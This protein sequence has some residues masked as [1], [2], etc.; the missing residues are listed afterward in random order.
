MQESPVRIPSGLVRTL[1]ERLADASE[2]QT[3]KEILNMAGKDRETVVKWLKICGKKRSCKVECPYEDGT[4]KIEHC[5]EK[6]MS[7]AYDLLTEKEEMGWIKTSV[8]TPDDRDWYLGIFQETD[9]GWINPIP[10]ICDYVGFITPGTTK[11]GWIIRDCTDI[12]NPHEYHLNLHCV[13]WTWLPEPYEHT[14]KETL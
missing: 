12:D 2:E 7:D 1:Q 11:E 8:R 5:R 4:G 9:T 14:E 13:A 6:L 3:A 10:F